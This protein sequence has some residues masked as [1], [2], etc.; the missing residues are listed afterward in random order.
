M[1]FEFDKSSKTVSELLAEE[2]AA[3]DTTCGGRGTCGKCR[4]RA[5]GKLSS[6]TAAERS[7]LTREEIAAGVRLA[8]QVKPAGPC[9][10][11]LEERRGQ[12]I[13]TG[14]MLPDFTFGPERG[15]LGFAVDVGT[16]TLAGYLYDLKAAKLLNEVSA[17]NPQ[18]IYGA[19]VISRMQ[20]SLEGGERELSDCI[21]RGIDS[22]A[23]KA[24]GNRAGDIDYIVI[25]GNTAMLYLLTGRSV[26]SV[27]RAPFEAD[28]LF[29]ETVTA[30]GLGLR[31]PK[32]D[33]AVYLCRSAS[34]YVGADITA[35]A[36]SSRL[37]SRNGANLLIDVGTNGEMVLSIDGRMLC[38]STAAGPALEGAGISM[39]SGAVAGAVSRVSAENGAI[40]CEV[41]GGGKAQSICGSGIVDAVAAFLKLGAVDETGRINKEASRELGILMEADGE[42]G[43]RLADKLYITQKD[44]RAVQLAKA[45]ICAGCIAILKH[46]GLRPEEVDTLFLAGGFGSFIDPVSAER[47]GLIPAPLGRK[48]VV[49]GN[50]AGAGASMILL[51]GAERA[52]SE[53][54]ASCMETV[55]LYKDEIFL[56]EYINR[57]IFE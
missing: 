19:D 25:A 36:L 47:I 6:I 55:P 3:P 39:G 35:A 4:V 14:G 23:L 29:G 24:A 51:S 37:A 56:E 40:A 44:I 11:R 42:E 22:L 8:C 1:I 34:A 26:G 13:L 54:L 50:A 12:I 31:I 18:R 16:T 43:L 45:A 41:I 27:A 17:L 28:C 48:A 57:M 5:S 46:C 53:A 9:S 2:G 38:C 49:L 33:A 7:L 10:V 15:T 21:L 30:S 52:A 32:K 20:K